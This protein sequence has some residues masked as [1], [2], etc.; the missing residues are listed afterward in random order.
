MQH[1]GKLISIEKI[2]QVLTEQKLLNNKKNIQ[3]DISLL[4]MET[5]SRKVAEGDLFICISGY[6]VDGHDFAESASKNGAGLLITEKE[7]NIS[8]PQFIVSNSR[9]ASAFLAQ[10]FFD[11]PSAKFKLIGITGTNGKTTTANMLGELFLKLGK[12]VGIIGTL[13]YK[14]NNTEYPSQLTT[15]D[16]TEL[17]TIFN[18]MIEAEVEYVI[19]EVSSH[20][21]YLDRVSGLHFDVGI[22]TN[23]T[24]DHLDFH[25]NMEN[26]FQAK[27]LLFQ[28]LEKNSG[29]AYINIDNTYG[30]KIFNDLNCMKYGISFNS[31]D[32]S[33]SDINIAQSSSSFCLKLNSASYLLK[34]SF[35][36]R[37]NILNISLAASVLLGIFPEIDEMTLDQ[38][39]S[40]LSPVH[41]RLESIRNDLGLHIY[42]DYAHSPDALDNVLSSLQLLKKGRLICVFGAGGE[43]DKEKR[44]MML[45]SALKYTDLAI[46]TSDNP[47]SEPVESIIQDIVEGTDPGEK[48]LIIRDRKDAIKTAVELAVEKDIILIAGKGHENY[49]QIGDNKLP[50]YDK[51]VVEDWLQNCD[52]DVPEG[53]LSIPL[54]LLQISDQCNF[55]LNI[56]PGNISFKHISTDS[57]DIHPNSLFIALKGENFD[58][59]DYVEDILKVE[60]CWA[61]V[62]DDYESASNRLIRVD[63]PL[64]AMGDLA[65]KYAGLFAAKR[66]A[67]TGSMGKTTTKEYLYNILS[68]EAPTHRTHSNENNLIGLPKTIFKLKPDYKFVI[69]ELGSNHFGEIGRLAEI[70]NPEMAVITSIGSSHLEFFQDEAGVF[71]EKKALFDRKLKLRFFPGEDK[72]FNQYF[73][74]TF[75]TT[76]DCDYRT[77]NITKTENS[78]EFLVNG[79]KFS[80]PTLYDTFTQNAVIAISICKELSVSYES[81]Q[82][83]LNK[84]LS[85]PHR[86]EMI[87]IGEMTVLA[88]CYNANPQSMKAAIKFW[89]DLKKDLPHVA[90]LGDML[91]LGDIAV[92]LHENIGEIVKNYHSAQVISVGELA[93]NYSANVHFDNVE[94]LN[95]SQIAEKLPPDA[96]ILL[97][98]SHGIKL[99]KFLKRIEL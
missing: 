87:E 48:Y 4:K 19:M 14:I 68:L 44:P 42:V 32:I 53:E 55:K 40:S 80:I 93:E 2:E 78:T 1:S 20:S 31:G 46:V 66:I 69:Y 51:E 77:T 98:A 50:F 12:K 24:R 96:V 34:S 81:I 91:E 29:T 43:R 27:A 90:I 95:N 85:V 28:M 65:R 82:K 39:T 64:K 49:Q 36:A 74:I 17:N 94:D 92:K 37:H 26:Y 88:D 38:L 22:F 73:G 79:S 21:L 13:G 97:K 15:P 6:D 3:Q 57:R 59:H 23:L 58:G 25:E 63:D 60:N 54:D 10:L 18:I 75:G 11:D 76:E 35:I 99:E 47:R 70:C 83:G 71:S 67:I 5:D 61:L 7:L 45:K 30:Q 52:T 56:D 84:P 41:G 9:K 16:V 86:M 33:I 8:I 62:K 72:R 89:Q